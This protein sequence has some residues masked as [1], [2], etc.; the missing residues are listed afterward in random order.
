MSDIFQ[1][2]FLQMNIWFCF[3]PCLSL[4]M[5]SSNFW[6]NC[7]RKSRYIST[8]Y[9]VKV[10]FVWHSNPILLNISNPYSTHYS[11]KSYFLFGNSGNGLSWI[12]GFSLSPPFSLSFGVFGDPLGLRFKFWFSFRSELVVGDVEVVVTSSSSSPIGDVEVGDDAGDFPFNFGWKKI[13]FLN[14]KF[15]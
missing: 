2:V 3:I 4:T 12:L 11:V 9:E 8:Y 15:V 14:D 7:S 10:D 13:H 6:D 5:F 1:F